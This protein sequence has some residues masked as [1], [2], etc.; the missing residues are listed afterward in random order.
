MSAIQHCN[1]IGSLK[2]N[3]QRANYQAKTYKI[4]VQPNIMAPHPKDHD[5]KPTELRVTAGYLM[6]LITHP[7]RER[8]TTHKLQ[9]EK[10][11]CNSRKCSCKRAGIKCNTM[12]KCGQCTN[13]ERLQNVGIDSDSGHSDYTD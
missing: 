4:C 11:P 2:L 8:T 1:Q 12:C 9:L 5:W 10:A 7:S 13:C 6:E 3:I